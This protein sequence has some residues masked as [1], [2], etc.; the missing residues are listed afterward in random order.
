M[1]NN[2]NA[3]K[4]PAL[5]GEKAIMIVGVQSGTATITVT[6]AE[7]QAEPAVL[8]L[9]VIDVDGDRTITAS[10]ITCLYN[11][12][13]NGDETYIS[14]SDTDGDGYITSSDVTVVYNIILGN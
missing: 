8:N 10:D 14:T 9:R 13:L 11:Y 1:I 5:A 4:T 7:G 6:N 12:I 2:T 3:S